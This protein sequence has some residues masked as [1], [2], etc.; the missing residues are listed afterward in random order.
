MNTGRLKL[1]SHLLYIVL[2]LSYRFCNSP[3]QNVIRKEWD[4]DNGVANGWVLAQRQTDC[5]IY[6]Y[7]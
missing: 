5:L 4:M 1:S 7:F 3:V 6:S 2:G